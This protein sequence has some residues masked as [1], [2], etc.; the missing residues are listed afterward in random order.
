MSYNNPTS[1]CHLSFLSLTLSWAKNKSGNT[2]NTGCHCLASLWLPL[3]LRAWFTLSHPS[4]VDVCDR[5][6]AA[7]QSPRQS[8]SERDRVC[9]CEKKKKENSAH[10]C[11]VHSF[12]SLSP[13][14]SFPL[15]SSS[16]AMSS[17][18]CQQSQAHRLYSLF[19]HYQAS[20]HAK[21]DDP[22]VR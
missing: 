5:L 9:L 15:C 13:L 8:T 12:S 3:S 1:D 18:L 6:H 11:F 10:P 4:P 20:Y 7:Q 14:S 21:H 2:D 17:S 16:P 19:L 22:E